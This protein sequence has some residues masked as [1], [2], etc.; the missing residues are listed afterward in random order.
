[1]MQKCAWRVESVANKMTKTEERLA[2]MENQAK[3][4]KVSTCLIDAKLTE[5]KAVFQEQSQLIDNHADCIERNHKRLNKV[6][7]DLGK[8][9]K[10]V[11]EMDAEPVVSAKTFQNFVGVVTK[12]IDELH[13][14]IA[15]IEK[16]KPEVDSAMLE[17]HVKGIIREEIRKIP[18]TTSGPALDFPVELTVVCTQSAFPA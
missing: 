8:V 4:Q 1:M 3:E 16:K 10:R 11:Q 15:S 7:T 13:S 18:S 17:G 9:T 2:G 14:D 5:L 6:V 12:N